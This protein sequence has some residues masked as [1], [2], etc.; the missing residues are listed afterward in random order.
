[1]RAFYTM[2]KIVMTK[3]TYLDEQWHSC[4]L[5]KAGALVQ[6]RWA[7]CHSARAAQTINTGLGQTNGGGTPE[8]RA[9]FETHEALF[10]ILWSGNWQPLRAFFPF[11]SKPPTG[12]GNLKLGASHNM[13]YSPTSIDFHSFNMPTALILYLEHCFPYSISSF[14]GF[15]LHSLDSGHGAGEMSWSRDFCR[16]SPSRTQR[17]KFKSQACSVPCTGSPFSSHSCPFRWINGPIDAGSLQAEQ[18]KCTALG[19]TRLMQVLGL[20]QEQ[21]EATHVAEAKSTPESDL[22]IRLSF[23]FGVLNACLVGD[24]LFCIRRQLQITQQHADKLPHRPPTRNSL[25]HV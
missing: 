9:P 10:A 15:E 6:W 25:V 1:M 18:L 24:R 17:W 22:R 16:P 23:T 2:T 20:I 3:Q 4:S 8:A 19:A 11:S 12:E 5:S 21:T 14:L 7:K 13:G